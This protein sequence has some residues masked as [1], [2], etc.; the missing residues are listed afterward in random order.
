M[1]RMVHTPSALAA[2]ESACH[3]DRLAHVEIENVVAILGGL[4]VSHRACDTY[5]I[6]LG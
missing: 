3:L 4:E 1:A 2:V 5:H 6:E